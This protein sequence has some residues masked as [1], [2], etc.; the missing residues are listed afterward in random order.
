M[1]TFSAN[2][3]KNISNKVTRNSSALYTK[4][5]LPINYGYI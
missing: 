2:R 3:E 5:I 4:N 1:N